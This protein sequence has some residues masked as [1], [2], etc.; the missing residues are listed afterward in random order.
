V[1]CSAD[2]AH[3]NNPTLTPPCAKNQKGYELTS[4][5][6]CNCAEGYGSAVDGSV[7]DPPKSFPTSCNPP[8]QPGEKKPK[9]MCKCR[10]CKTSN[11]PDKDMYGAGGP[12]TIAKCTTPPTNNVTLPTAPA[13]M[14]ASYQTGV[15]PY[16]GQYRWWVRAQFGTPA[17]PVNL[18]FDSG[19]FAVHTCGFNAAASSTAVSQNY[20]T[21]L[22]ELLVAFFG[23]PA[24]AFAAVVVLFCK[25]LLPR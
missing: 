9:D 5:G 20:S 4:S 21:V 12:V 8:P 18:I 2:A 14:P 13:R 19:S 24:A 15:S 10:K 7:P 3:P 11:N 23:L 25:S 6:G 17:Q 22:S 1:C 16:T